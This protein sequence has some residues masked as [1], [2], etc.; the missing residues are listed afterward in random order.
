[1]RRNIWIGFTIAGLLVCTMI[2]AGAPNFGHTQ[3][4][5]PVLLGAHDP[6]DPLVP[7]DDTTPP[8]TTTTT[9]V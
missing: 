3:T 8:P 4:D 6:I 7:V 5:Q 9:M 2:T 1:M